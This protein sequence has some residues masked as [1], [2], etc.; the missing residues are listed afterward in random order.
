MKGNNRLDL[1]TEFLAE[2]LN[3]WIL[4]PP[5]LIVLHFT[6]AKRPD[7]LMWSLAGLFPFLFFRIRCKVRNLWLFLGAHLAV[8]A[9]SLFMPAAGLVSRLLCVLC[10][11]LYMLRSF[12][13]SLKQREPGDTEVLSPV[14]AVAVYA[15][16]FLLHFYQGE[17]RGWEK[18]YLVTLIAYFALYNIVQYLQ[19]F[20]DFLYLNSSSAGRLPARDMLRSGLG[21]VLG[22]T[23][24]GAAVMLLGVN[25]V[26]LERLADFLKR[27]LLALIRAF[28]S[29]FR[30]GEG[31]QEV[32]SEQAVPPSAGQLPP[33][34]EEGETFWL[35]KLLEITIEIVLIGLFLYGLLRGLISLIRW[36]RRNFFSGGRQTKR[37]AEKEGGDLRERCDLSEQKRSSGGFSVSLLNPAAR[38]RKLYK[39]ALLSRTVGE[40]RSALSY[41][42]A[43]EG[44]DKTGL[45]GMAEVYEK[46]RYSE[47][48]LTGED[49]KRMKEACSGPG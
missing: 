5:V 20:M 42:T 40:E 3:H 35:W 29:L 17:M 16:T 30:P 21:L 25:A 24:L 39:R 11:V 7:L 38:I 41:L 12:A 49:V 15:L 37:L 6:G 43:R 14:L 19:H 9:L 34:P 32:L 23:L 26:W 4:F 46:A 8:A 18:Y 28:F 31:A 2:Q 22:Y 47:R 33:L 45:S 44:E 48:K 27:G 1:I 36:I 10:A 13:A